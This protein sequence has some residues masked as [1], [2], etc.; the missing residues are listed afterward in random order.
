[1]IKAVAFAVS[2]MVLPTVSFAQSY[3]APAPTNV[4]TTGTR[5]LSKADRKMAC[6][7]TADRAGLKG[8][9]RQQYRAA[10]RGRPIPKS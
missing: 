6:T 3:S 7:G 4:P 5:F 10:C 1:M 8:L 9:R 2:L